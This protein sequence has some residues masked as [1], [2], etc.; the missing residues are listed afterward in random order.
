[1]LYLARMTS[2]EHVMNRLRP[3]TKLETTRWTKRHFARGL[4]A[5]RPL[6]PASDRARAYSSYACI[7]MRMDGRRSPARQLDHRGDAN[8]PTRSKARTRTGIAQRVLCPGRSLPSPRCVRS[9]Y[10][11]RIHEDRLRCRAD[12]LGKSVSRKP[13]RETDPSTR[14]SLHTNCRN[15]EL[16]HVFMCSLASACVNAI[17]CDLP[18]TVVSK[19][20]T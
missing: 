10:T 16:L 4:I 17:S 15:R 8:L 12:S 20:R 14:N 9:P 7:Y 3:R 6:H 2:D 18:K 13:S 11:T 1:M 19:A 5:D